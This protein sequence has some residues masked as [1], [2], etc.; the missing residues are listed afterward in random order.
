MKLISKSKGCDERLSIA[1]D[2]VIG[3]ALLDRGA[4]CLCTAS[5]QGVDVRV[6]EEGGG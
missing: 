4:I 5:A 2:F 6:E 1:T 3:M